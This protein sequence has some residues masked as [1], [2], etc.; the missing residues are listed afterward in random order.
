MTAQAFLVTIKDKWEADCNTLKQL[1]TGT[2][3]KPRSFKTLQDVA[4]NGVRANKKTAAAE[5]ALNGEK[6]TEQMIRSN[7][8]QFMK[9]IPMKHIHR[10]YSQTELLSGHLAAAGYIG[11]QYVD[12]FKIYKDMLTAEKTAPVNTA[13]V[14]DA[15]A[16]KADAAVDVNNTL[17]LKTAVVAPPSEAAPIAKPQLTDSDLETIRKLMMLDPKLALDLTHALQKA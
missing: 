7:T 5:A 4:M 15:V 9:H 11:D 12:M 8:A 17:G 14:T 6:M 1:T 16:S 3:F 13:A 2:S 10:M